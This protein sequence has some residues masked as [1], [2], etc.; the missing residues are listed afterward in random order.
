VPIVRFEDIASASRFHQVCPAST[1]AAPVMAFSFGVMP[2]AAKEAFRSRRLP[3]QGVYELD[4]VSL[5]GI[6]LLTRGNVALSSLATRMPE[7]LLSKDFELLGNPVRE[8]T[9]LAVLITGTGERVWGHWLV[10][11]LPKLY[12][13]EKAGFDPST[14][15]FLWPCSVRP[16]A[17]KL[18]QTFGIKPHQLLPY[19][20][21]KETLRLARLLVPTI[22]HNHLNA[23]PVFAEA[24]NFLSA[25]LGAIGTESEGEKIFLARGDGNRSLLGRERITAIMAARGFRVLRPETLPIAAQFDL[26]RSAR[27]VAGEYG[28]AMHGT[29]FSPLGTVVFALHGNDLHPGFLQTGIGAALGQPTG[30]VF[31]EP[32]SK[33]NRFA[34]TESDLESGLDAAETLAATRSVDLSDKVHRPMPLIETLYQR[35]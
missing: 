15:S 21:Q 35:P 18:M 2:A 6:S 31:G 28:S 30:Y 17:G 9:E 16:F 22:L 34:I 10:D 3:E 26:F 27:I 20:P 12:L 29:M 33:P 14:L 13:L 24:A 1:P 23:S 11:F 25:R 32:G 8:I 7:G 19:D 4:T 5:S